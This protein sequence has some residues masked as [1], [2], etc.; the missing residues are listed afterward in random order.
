[1][2]QEIAVSVHI[3]AL[4]ALATVLYLAIT[5]LESKKKEYAVLFLFGSCIIVIGIIIQ[6]MA[7]TT[8]GALIGI[9][10]LYLG[11][12]VMIPS[13]YTFIQHYFDVPMPKIVN[14]ANFV[15]GLFLTFVIWVPQWRPLLFTSIYLHYE[16]SHSGIYT[17]TYTRGILYPAVR[18]YHVVLAASMIILLAKK[19]RDSIETQRRIIII[20]ICSVAAYIIPHFLII[21]YPNSYVFLLFV[22][23]PLVATASALLYIVFFKETM[24]ENEKAVQLQNTIN[25]MVANISHDLK[26][27]LTVLSVSLEK[28]LGI[29]PENSVYSQHTQ[30]AYNKNLDLQRLIQNLIEVTRIESIQNLYNPEWIHLNDLLSNIHKKYSG[31][32]ESIGLTFD[33][34]GIGGDNHILVDPSKV[35][36]VF[37]NI[38]YNAIR[39]THTGG[40]T[41]MASS[42]IENIAKN[43]R[44]NKGE[45]AENDTIS[46]T[47]TDTGVGIA[48]EH[49]PRIY[50]RFYKVESNRGAQMGESGLGLYI[51]RHIMEGSQGS[52]EMV[53]E[54]GV[55]TSVIL[56]F[57]CKNVT[58]LEY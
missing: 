31:H 28:L 45:T 22:N 40:I 25:D 26:T 8:E 55:G 21:L 24:L 33:V 46:I 6:L 17:W 7:V 32:L 11:A 54:V 12:V 23:M 13:I 29:L 2:I 19:V 43:T 42:G 15:I 4:F 47:I 18:A 44:S 5:Q 27:P 36:S 16:P 37:D 58:V 10:M 3:I 39:H 1:M 49:L 35:W 20:L 53:S 51:A 57:A 48:P 52:I 50:E 56:S 30:V 34:G 9:K 38:I 14:Y 41:V